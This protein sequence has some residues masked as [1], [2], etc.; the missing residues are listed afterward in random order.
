M[1]H[2]GLNLCQTLDTG[3]SDGLHSIFVV[4]VFLIHC[5]HG[6]PQSHVLGL[7][8]CSGLAQGNG[9]GY[10]VFIA[11]I[12][13]DQAAVALFHTKHIVTNAGALLF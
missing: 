13:T 3:Q 10:G 8:V 4:A 12:G 11:G 7:V 6:I 5:Y 9:C 2:N 1:L